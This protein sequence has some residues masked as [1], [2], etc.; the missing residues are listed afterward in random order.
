MSGPHAIEKYARRGVPLAISEFDALFPLELDSF[1][2]AEAQAA[3]ISDDIAYNAHDLDDGLRAGLFDLADMRDVDF[4]RDI[5]DEI[6][7]RHPGLERPRM[8]NEIVR[9]VITRFVED[10]IGESRLRF[11]AAQPRD[12]AAVRNAGR[13]LVAFSEKFSAVDAALKA[14]LYPHMY[15]HAR[16]MKVRGEAGAVVERLFDHYAA[17]GSPMPASWAARAGAASGDDSRRL[18][19]VTDYIAGMTDRYALS[20]HR[21]LFGAAPSITIAFS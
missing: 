7:M 15:R 6:E 13:A 8:V 14:F 20:E 5:V 17:D 16:V 1:A 12:A 10:A 11:E 3:A 18:R 4:L 9:R 21:R 2:S 19:V